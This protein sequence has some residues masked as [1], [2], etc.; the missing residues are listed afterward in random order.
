M[1]ESIKGVS[2]VVP[3]EDWSYV[4]NLIK[5]KPDFIIHGDDWKTNYLSKI[6]EDV[7]ETMKAWGGQVIEIPYTQGINST[8]LANN[9]SVIG[10]TPDVRLKACGASLLPSLSCASWKHIPA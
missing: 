3:Q 9:A 4:P 10:T 6:R 2:R 5:Y 1:V 7:F 8:E